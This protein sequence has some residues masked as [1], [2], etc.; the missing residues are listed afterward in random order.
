M[1]EAKEIGFGVGPGADMGFEEL[2]ERAD[3]VEDEDDFGL[4]DRFHTQKKQR[5]LDGEGGKEQEVVT[6]QPGVMRVEPFC[7][8]D[9]S[10]DDRAEEA[11]PGLLEGE[12]EKLPE[13]GV[14]P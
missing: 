14:E 8:E 10:E 4:A 13:E 9:E 1:A 3:D 11:G 2:H 5:R 12:E 6:R 7:E